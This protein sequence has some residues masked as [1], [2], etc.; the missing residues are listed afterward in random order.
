MAYKT[1]IRG[2]ITTLHLSHPPNPIP[3]TLLN[4]MKFNVL[5]RS[6]FPRR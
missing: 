3:K 5:R 4:G 2:S 6:P 1:T